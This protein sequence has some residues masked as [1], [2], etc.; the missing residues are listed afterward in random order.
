MYHY[1]RP[2]FNTDLP[3]DAVDGVMAGSQ[4]HSLNVNDLTA[5]PKVKQEK[6]RKPKGKVDPLLTT[7][8]K[9]IAIQRK[10]GKKKKK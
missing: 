3:P 2:S 1:T 10:K 6:V 8:S 7:R 4:R 9:P 5:I